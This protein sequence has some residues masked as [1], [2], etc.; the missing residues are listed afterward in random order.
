MYW[1]TREGHLGVVA[2]LMAAGGDPSIP[3]RYGQNASQIAFRSADKQ[4][5][6]LILG[7]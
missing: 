7:R 1:A 6:L 4:L 2:A 5:R 3:D